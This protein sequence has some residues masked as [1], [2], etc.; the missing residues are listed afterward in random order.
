MDDVVPLGLSDA[1]MTA[2]HSDSF[3]VSFWIHKK[4][5]TT[6]FLFGFRDDTAS[7]QEE[8]SIR[9]LNI[10]AHYLQTAVAH[11]GSTLS[12][13]GAITAPATDTWIHFAASVTKGVGS[14]AGNAKFYIDGSQVVSQNTASG[15]NHAAASI[16]SGFDYVVGAKQTN[17]TP[18]Y[19]G[20]T[21]GNF[22]EVALWDTA[23][24]ADEI[25]AIYN[26]GSTFDLQSD[27]GNYTSSSNLQYYYRFENNFSDTMGNGGD[28]TNPSGGVTF[29]SIIT[30]P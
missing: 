22:D 8:F 25:T 29:N 4:A 12:G 27:N 14:A 26:S 17:S 18:T 23:L 9:Y 24:S 21:K 2:L 19:T 16:A 28:A 1:Q 6:S 7:S 3:S 10:G 30:A 20:Y 5:W 15:T 13:L 11:N